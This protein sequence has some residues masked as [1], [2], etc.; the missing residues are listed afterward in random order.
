MP[1]AQLGELH[2]ATAAS[3]TLWVLFVIVQQHHNPVLQGDT[4]ARAAAHSATRRATHGVQCAGV[5]VVRRIACAVALS[6]QVQQLR[7]GSIPHQAVHLT[8]ATLTGLSRP[9]HACCAA[10]TNASCPL[11]CGKQIVA[12]ASTLLCSSAPIKGPSNTPVVPV[13][14]RCAA[15]GACPA[16][17]RSYRSHLAL[18]L[19]QPQP[20]QAPRLR[21]PPA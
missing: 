19:R 14:R 12:I 2:S 7:R 20:P 10:T 11:P 3:A 9:R 13:T 15:G 5:V 21:R 18:W 17:A 1:K 4:T 16:C 8:R 6:R